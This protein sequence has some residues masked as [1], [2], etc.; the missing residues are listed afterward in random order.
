MFW[1]SQDGEEITSRTADL[2]SRHEVDMRAE[3]DALRTQW[4]DLKPVLPEG[5][6]GILGLT[7]SSRSGAAAR[8]RLLLTDL[9]LIAKRSE[10]DQVSMPGWSTW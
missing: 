5:E 10:V 8:S 3:T 2:V 9:N 7:L 6:S 4:L 1:L